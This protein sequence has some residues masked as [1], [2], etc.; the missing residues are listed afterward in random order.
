MIK[1]LAFLL[2]ISLF[3]S[4][5]KTQNI[6]DIKL[7]LDFEQIDVVKNST[8]RPLVEKYLTNLTIAGP[9]D[10][11]LSLILTTVTVKLSNIKVLDFSLNW[12]K[13]ALTPVDE[14]QVALTLFD[15]DI[16]IE[17]DYDIHYLSNDMVG[18]ANITVENLTLGITLQFFNSSTSSGF[19]AII[20]NFSMNYDS[21]K[22]D[23]S[24]KILT[25]L[26]DQIFSVFKCV[27]V[28]TV[29]NVVLGDISNKVKDLTS[30]VIQIP[31]TPSSLENLVTQ[32]LKND[33]HMP[34]N[35]GDTYIFNISMTRAPYVNF[36]KNSTNSFSYLTTFINLAVF[37]NRTN[38]TPAFKEYDLLPF[39]S[40]YAHDIQLYLVN[41]LL[42]QIQWV[43][44]DS[45]ILHLTLNDKMLPSSSP[46]H[47]NTSF[48]GLLLPGIP[49]KYGE[50][51][52]IY[53]GVSAGSP[54]SKI[55]FRGGR[56][57]GE[58]SLVMDFIVDK[59]STNY[60]SDKCQNCETA[61]SINTTL[62]L[63]LHADDTNGTLIFANILNIDFFNIGVL[64]KVIDFDASSFQTLMKDVGR[65]FIPVLNQQLQNIPNPLIGKYGIKEMSFRFSVD[66]IFLRVAFE[67][68]NKMI[69]V[70]I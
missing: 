33:F 25:W 30:N 8:L 34:K 57:V 41:N 70:E 11:N 6:A 58:V 9:I 1:T 65:S 20:T 49:V 18:R 44:L 10:L 67:Q 60:P 3:F 27:L 62:L 47:L 64:N 13:T 52:G 17:N 50:G 68:D 63:A 39:R 16:K 26:V 42:T 55:V 14:S 37:N 29:K 23:V 48:I 61:I 40:F 66:Y 12:D 59:D 54:Y 46:L 36:F 7:S 22:M 4:N 19:Y 5:F 31:L 38:A 45:N 32:T 56:L 51:K 24:S 2:F 21:L 15:V 35:T 69:V 53:L 28:K 43:V